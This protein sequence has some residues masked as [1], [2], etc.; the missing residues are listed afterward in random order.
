MLITLL[1]LLVTLPAHAACSRENPTWWKPQ[2]KLRWYTDY[3]GELPSAAKKVDVM[4]LSL[5][6]VAG[7]PGG[8]RALKASGKKIVCYTNSGALEDGHWDMALLRR[9]LSESGLRESDLIG[10]AMDGYGGERWLNVTRLKELEI[11]VEARF[12]KAKSAG[13]D[14]VDPDNVEAW[15]TGQDAALRETFHQGG[16]EA[17][18][19]EAR[20]KVKSITGFDIGYQDQLRYNRMLAQVAHRN[21]LGIDLKNDVYQIHDLADD[22]DFA[23]NE[24]CHHCGWCELYRPLVERSKPVFGLEYFDN[25]GFCG[26]GSP[27][28]AKYCADDVAKSLT[29]LTVLK[30]RASSQL[31]VP[32]DGVSCPKAR[33][34][35]K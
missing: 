16:F 2:G 12:K 34:P 21:C 7:D 15:V 9:V 10:K 3:A 23:V 27:E 22:F 25:E 19:R 4:V 24:Q 28:P 20:K 26:P 5:N 13:C 35:E 6:T 31:H 30:K 11:L 17:V 8:V 29:T 1:A 18:A 14:A 32:G 33:Q